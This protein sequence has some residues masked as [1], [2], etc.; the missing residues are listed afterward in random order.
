M[1]RAGAGGTTVSRRPPLASGRERPP[2][3]R[4]QRWILDRGALDALSQ[5]GWDRPRRRIIAWERWARR[6]L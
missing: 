6:I 3:H 5:G 4:W 1:Y 2:R